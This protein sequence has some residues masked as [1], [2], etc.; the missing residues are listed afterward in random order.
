MLRGSV[1]RA[2]HWNFDCL[3]AA[4]VL[5]AR[6]IFPLIDRR[7]DEHQYLLLSSC[8]YTLN[9]HFHSARIRR[10]CS[11]N[12]T[13][14]MRCNELT[15]RTEVGT[16]SV[17][18]TMTMC[19]CYH[20]PAH[21]SDSPAHIPLVVGYHPAFRSISSIFHELIHLFLSSSHFVLLCW[22]I[23]LSLPSYV[24]TSRKFAK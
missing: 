6:C 22:N 15:Q 11:S 4:I 21:A 12:E 9:E 5:L 24:L 13:F 19:T 23:Y 20:T 8:I 18:S 16:V 14:K 1:S 10:I 3:T 2:R 7:T 17:S